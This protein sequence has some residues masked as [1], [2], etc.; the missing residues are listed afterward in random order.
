MKM[1]AVAGK[2]LTGIKLCTDYFVVIGAHTDPELGTFPP[3]LINDA[4]ILTVN[5]TKRIT[6]QHV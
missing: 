2:L 5:M 4:K 3:T 6:E 1:H